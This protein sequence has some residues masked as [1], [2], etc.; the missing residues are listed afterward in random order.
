[1][2]VMLK[3]SV[4][5]T[6]AMNV[7][8]SSQAGDTKNI[9]TNIEQSFKT[10]TYKFDK[11]E[12]LLEQNY[13]SIHV[14]EEQIK[15]IQLLSTEVSEQVKSIGVLINYISIELRKILPDIISTIE[16]HYKDKS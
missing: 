7:F 5:R 1:M 12:H 10:Y 6:L 4:S 15:T 14:Q 13:K 2:H 3:N 11:F 9:I 16:S 8:G